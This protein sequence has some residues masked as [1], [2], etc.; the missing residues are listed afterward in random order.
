MRERD[1]SSVDARAICESILDKGM[2]VAGALWRILDC[3]DP[4][5]LAERAERARDEI[6]HFHTVL[7]NIA[8]R[9]GFRRGGPD[10]LAEILRDQKRLPFGD[11]D[12]PNA[13]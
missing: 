7:E 9:I 11:P 5:R 12:L 13:A 6:R 3:D 1:L 10:R 4:E 8:R 2:G